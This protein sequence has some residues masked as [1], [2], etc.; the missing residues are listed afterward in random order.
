MTLTKK[1]L[2]DG[3]SRVTVTLTPEYERSKKLCQEHIGIALTH[4]QFIEFLTR[5]YIKH[6]G[7]SSV[8]TEWRVPWRPGF[9]DRREKEE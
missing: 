1:Q 9:A 4:G 2:D 6:E 7:L 8:K 5:Y 3:M